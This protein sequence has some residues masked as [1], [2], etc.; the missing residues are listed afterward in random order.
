MGQGRYP[1]MGLDGMAAARGAS[2]LY[3]SPA[4]VLDGGTCGTYTAVDKNGHIAGGGIGLGVM[5]KCLAVTSIMNNAVGYQEVWDR[6]RELVNAN[7]KVDIFARDTCSAVAVQVIQDLTLT[8]R[9]LIKD[10]F[11]TM[12]YMKP[13]VQASG[14]P[15]SEG[16]KKAAK[17]KPKPK[18]C[19]TGGD[20]SILVKLLDRDAPYLP[21]AAPSK[22]DYDI[23]PDPTLS[24][25]G[26]AAALKNKACDLADK[27]QDE[28]CSVTRLLIGKR[29]VDDDDLLATI[30]AV[31]SEGV[32]DSEKKFLARYDDG[33]FKT[34]TIKQVY[35]G[36][37]D[38]YTKGESAD[39]DWNPSLLVRE[40]TTRREKESNDTA[41][42]LE[43][44]KSLNLLPPEQ[45]MEEKEMAKPASSI[46]VPFVTPVATATSVAAAVSSL[47]QAP[48]AASL[49][50][51]PQATTVS[52]SSSLKPAPSALAAAVSSLK[53]APV[54]SSLKPAPQ[55]TPAT[56]AAASLKPA[57]IITTNAASVPGTGAPDIAAQATTSEQDTTNK[58]RVI[59]LVDNTATSAPPQKKARQQEDRN[60]R[61]IDL[62]DNTATSAPPQK[63]A[64][65]ARRSQSPKPPKQFNGNDWVGK[66]IAKEF[67][68][69]GG[70]D[71]SQLV[72]F[73]GTIIE[74]IH[75]EEGEDW[76][77]RYDDGDE[78]CLSKAD[79]LMLWKKHKVALKQ[80]DPMNSKKKNKRKKKNKILA[81]TIEVPY[82][83]ITGVTCIQIDFEAFWC[84][85]DWH[86][87]YDDGDEECLSKADLL[88][89]WKKH[90]AALQHKDPKKSKQKKNKRK[91]KK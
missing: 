61:V 91:K 54:A 7:T 59:D 17:S 23:F 26:V 31:Q 62:V 58:K 9:N 20:A 40:K 42:Q 30:Y 56:T 5:R 55:A 69:E 28:R 18:I 87:R 74:Y 66:R 83:N 6:I 37:K 53:Q 27:R 15:S 89:L 49:K 77:V 13:E 50:P 29:I 84:R 80:K 10:Y 64:K 36:L 24:L 25:L 73:F 2:T 12:G 51:A 1:G 75:D 90:K 71:V 34:L 3:G 68:P 85:E 21:D 19:V 63:K 41:I 52:A 38:Y 78:E 44:D 76:H 43:K 46:G 70:T 35:E 60:K 72:L 11:D 4:L 88:M 47:R 65:A 14:G 32:A 82:S 22:Y 16:Q 79:L 33:N 57:P 39:P 86:V 67:Y 48:T 8:G 81:R 45:V